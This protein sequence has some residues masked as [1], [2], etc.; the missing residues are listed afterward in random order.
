MALNFALFK[1]LLP[2]WFYTYQYSNKQFSV[3][4]DRSHIR[5]A[6]VRL[7]PLN[8]DQY[9]SI[10][11]SADSK[12]VEVAL[13]REKEP[14]QGR[15]RWRENKW[16]LAFKQ[17]FPL[18]VAM[19]VAAFVI[20]CLST[21]LLQHDFST[22]ALPLYEFWQVWAHWD[23]GHYMFIATQGYTIDRTVFF[24][25]YPLL[26]HVVMPLVRNNPFIAGVL[27]SFV[28]NLVWMVALYQLVLEDFS[29]EQAQRAALYL[30]IFPTAFFFMA[31]YTESLFLAL[32]LL[33]FYF[34]RR[35]RWWLS[36]IFGL[37]VCLTRSVGILLVLPFGYE[38]LRQHQF[39]IRKIRLNA[40]G[41]L[42]FPL[43]LALYAF[44]CWKI[45]GDPLSFSHQ[46]VKWNRH[47]SWPWWAIRES[48]SEIRHSAGLFGF[49]TLRNLTELLPDLL[50]LALIILASVGPWRLKKDRW[51]YL[52]YAIPVWLAFNLN[53]TTGSLPLQSFGR[54][55]L[56][57]FPAFVFLGILGSKYRW[58][59]LIY[60][61]AASSMAYFLLTEFLTN[62]WIT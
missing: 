11:Q 47:L 34:A 33:S 45:F 60:M 17:I 6:R 58:L 38:Y 13:E 53:P 55:M 23:T 41:G 20:T 51:A 30:S 50:V 2:A 39:Q 42:L 15:G 48:I 8:T 61:A 19:H 31:A 4:E 22:G 37:F 57:V 24:P 49:Y 40:L 18:F 25:L 52:F 9:Q 59:H 56:E 43:A 27:I 10:Q 12:T 14:A 46:E 29:Q 5:S 35:G 26:M 44:Y 3:R 36:G 62:H 1:N 7:V 16:L 28:A 21:L 32:A 54:Y